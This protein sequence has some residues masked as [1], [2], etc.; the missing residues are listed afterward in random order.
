MPYA[1]PHV[2]MATKPHAP[3]P[4]SL[5]TL[6]SSSGAFRFQPAYQAAVDLFAQEDSPTAVVVA[7]DVAAFG[8][9][10]AARAHGLRIP[11]D[12]S[13]VGFDDTTAASTCVPPLT[14][15]RQPFVEIGRAALRTLLRLAAREPLDSHRV[16]LAT[17][18]V[19]R[20][21]TAPPPAPS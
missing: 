15:V 3:A 18:L 5:L 9:I 2:Y 21:S 13:V 7:T 12:V 6:G 10:E 17:Q 4:A 14:T 16:E 11:D 20:A 19:V 1:T 8:V